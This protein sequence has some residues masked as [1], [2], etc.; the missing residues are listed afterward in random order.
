MRNKTGKKDAIAIL[1]E[2]S[3]CFNPQQLKSKK[4]ITKK[5][6]DK[7]INNSEALFSAVFHA[8]QA[9]ISISRLSNNQFKDVNEAFLNLFGYTRNEALGYKSY[10]LPAWDGG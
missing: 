3:Y 1:T 6:K 9:G 4:N 10:R 5:Q 7:A 8:S 2:K